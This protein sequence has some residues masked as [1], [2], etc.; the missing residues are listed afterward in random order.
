MAVKTTRKA[1]VKRPTKADAKNVSITDVV[2][3]VVGT[4]KK[5]LSG[6]PKKKPFGGKGGRKKKQKPIDPNVQREI[7]DLKREEA[8]EQE[9]VRESASAR[10]AAE[11]P[12]SDFFYSDEKWVSAFEDEEII[13]LIQEKYP[14]FANK[15]SDDQVLRKTIIYILNDSEF[16]EEILDR[17][18]MNVYEFFKFLYRTEPTLFKGQFVTR[19]Q[20]ALKDKS[21]ANVR[22]ADYKFRQLKHVRKPAK[23]NG[24]DTAT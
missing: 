2:N 1:Q 8:E 11:H 10:A 3:K 6:P 18:S 4:A 21:Y 9:T 15:K 17:Y 5:I 16:M 20:R 22:Q 23:K 24:D 13:S 14:A 19:I 7:D 12:A